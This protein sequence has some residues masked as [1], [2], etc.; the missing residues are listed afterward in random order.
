MY[1]SARE[2]NIWSKQKFVKMNVRTHSIVTYDNYSECCKKNQLTDSGLRRYL[3]NDLV[4]QQ[5]KDKH[6][7]FASVGMEQIKE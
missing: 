1:A 7:M 4:Y 5:D 2:I 6:C 3:D